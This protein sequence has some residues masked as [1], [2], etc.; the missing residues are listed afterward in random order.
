[1][2]LLLEHD[3]ATA[4]QLLAAIPV[5]TRSAPSL[6]A[7]AA[8]LRDD[9]SEDVL[10]LGPS[11]DLDSALRL[12]AEQR[13]SRPVLGVVLVRSRVDSAVLRDAMRVGVREVVRSDELAAL[14]EAVTRSLQLSRALRG[15]GDEQP[16]ASSA[17][18]GTVVT[19]FASKGGV[20]KT[21]LATNL[22]VAAAARGGRR[23]CLVDLDL[24]FG[25][26]ALTM[27]LTPARTLADAVGLSRLDETAVRSLVTSYGRGL[28]VL[29]APVDPG[30]SERIPVPLV[31]DLLQLLKGMYDVVVVDSP[32]AFSEHTLAAFDNTDTFVLVATLDIASVKNLKLAMETL[33]LL[34]YPRERRHVVLNRSD[35][36][37]GLTATDVE[38]AVGAPIRLQV[39][40]SRAVPLSVNRGI[41]L[42]VDAPG[43]PASTAIVGFMDR[44]VGPGPQA[45]TGQHAAQG[46]LLSRLRRTSPAA[47]R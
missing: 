13:S 1:M 5:P 12:A 8:Y 32:P 4:D 22:A 34:A 10:V 21:T 27:Q 40:S 18:H 9:T 7:A 41:P 23:V 3:P 14:S 31:A 37:V 46:G 38:K 24:A 11:V 29:A 47:S 25:D 19:V 28:D 6:S 44:L 20:G 33:D 39:P 30:A 26:V 2:A 43:H 36:D 16:S 35:A 15:Q 45:A 42:V 17:A